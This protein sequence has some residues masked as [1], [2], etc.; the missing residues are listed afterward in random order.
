MIEFFSA[1]PHK[2]RLIITTLCGFLSL[3]CSELNQIP[4]HIGGQDVENFNVTSCFHKEHSFWNPALGRENLP[5]YSP[6]WVNPHS[7]FLSSFPTRPWELNPYS[8]WSQEYPG[9]RKRFSFSLTSGNSFFQVDF[10]FIISYFC[11]LYLILLRT[12]SKIVLPAD[13]MFFVEE[14]LSKYP[15]S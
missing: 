13:L 2:D 3:L 6:C 7:S 8:P 5:L 12:F 11:V 9:D 10:G 4:L 1:H 15:C 14:S